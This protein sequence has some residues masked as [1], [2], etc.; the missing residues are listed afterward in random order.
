MRRDAG[1]RSRQE[2]RKT[3]PAEVAAVRDLERE[4]IRV[5]QLVGHLRKE[6]LFVLVKSNEKHL[7][8]TVAHELMHAYQFAFKISNCG[9]F[10][11]FEEATATW[12]EDYVYPD[13]Q[14]E[15]DYA[16][17]FLEHP[18]RPLEYD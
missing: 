7:L 3:S 16:G 5:H 11:W 13:D 2:Q 10:R 8:A 4:L 9:D 15:H 14:D 1:V 17:A 6:M 18:S 12:A